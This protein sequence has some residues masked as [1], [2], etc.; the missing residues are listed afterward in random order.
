MRQRVC[1]WETL[2][3][4]ETFRQSGQA[5]K[6]LRLQRRPVRAWMRAQVRGGQ[7]SSVTGQGFALL[8]PGIGLEGSRASRGFIVDSN[9]SKQ[10]KRA[11]DCL[12][13]S[14]Q[15]ARIGETYLLDDMLSISLFNSVISTRRLAA[16]P[17]FVLL[18]STCLASPRPR[19]NIRNNGIWCCC[20]R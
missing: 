8:R 9:L 11:G 3:P 2:Q 5:C 14:S 4:I 19:M 15:F 12:L 20:D 10:K 18:S 13:P 6:F 7:K 16:R 17:S 1:M